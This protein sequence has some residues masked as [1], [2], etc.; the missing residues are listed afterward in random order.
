LP[1]KCVFGAE[2]I[3][4]HYQSPAGRELTPGEA[5]PADVSEPSALVE[6]RETVGRLV[7]RDLIQRV[8]G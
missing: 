5:A 2:W 6:W 4:S 1:L 7:D 3:L 8:A